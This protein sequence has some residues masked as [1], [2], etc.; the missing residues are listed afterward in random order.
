MPDMEEYT[1]GEVPEEPEPL[2]HSH[3]WSGQEVMFAETYLRTGDAAKAYR[4]AFDV[5]RQHDRRAW[6]YASVAGRTLLNKPFMRDYID[7]CQA[8][9][10]ARM[11]YNRENILEELAK[12]AFA[13]V[14]D[15]TV[16]QRDGTMVTDLSGASR[17]QLAAIADLTIETFMVGK[18]DDAQ[19][20]RSVKV[21][22]APKIAALELLGKHYKMWTDRV[23]VDGD[24][25][26]AEEMRRARAE[27]VRR[28]KETAS[29]QDAIDAEPDGESSD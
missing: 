3:D 25:D 7:E 17:E 13:N 1:L 22:L 11:V 15:F 20:V 5:D 6:L 4:I 9:L 2:W 27:R 24:T 21:K 8:T 29:G 10:K 16:L 12:L 28:Q 26:V 18:G 19:E 14:T 23:E